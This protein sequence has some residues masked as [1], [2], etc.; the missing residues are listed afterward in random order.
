MSGPGVLPVTIPLRDGTVLRV[1]R[2]GVSLY[3]RRHE[4]E[5]I[6]DARQ[7]APEPETIALRIS[8]VGLLE[9]QPE[10]TGDGLIALEGLYRLRPDLRPAGFM[11]LSLAPGD[12][13]PP[14]A[15]S[16]GQGYPAAGYY[17]PGY[18]A[19]QYAPAYGRNPNSLGGELTPYPRRFGEV[20]A[21]IFQLFGKHLPQWLVLGLLV[22]VIPGIL[23]GAF[24]LLLSDVQGPEMLTGLPSLPLAGGGQSSSC[25]L[26]FYVPPTN[27]LVRDVG[28]VIGVLALSAVF[29]ALEASTLGSAAREAL[30]GRRV[31]VKMSLAG[32]LRRLPATLGTTVL[33]GVIFFL[34]LAP[35]IATFEVALYHLS[36]LNLCDTNAVISDRLLFGLLLNLVGLVLFV[37]GLVLA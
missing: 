37:P 33:L 21:A 22:G 3:G 25:T 7:V 34:L 27:V 6:Q 8:G 13:P 35:G 28:L 19:P 4:L 24:Q 1:A 2:D 20:L 31:G 26:T 12:L 23:S 15:P 16:L 9:F 17:A 18:V 29:G 11:P 10:R 32:G 5:R 30:V 14:P 36:G